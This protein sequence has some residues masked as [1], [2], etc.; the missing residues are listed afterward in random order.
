L[1]FRVDPAA[2][3]TFVVNSDSWQSRNH[4]SAEYKKAHSSTSVILNVVLTGPDG[5]P[6]VHMELLVVHRWF[7]KSLIKRYWKS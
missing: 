3:I 7:H 2:M 4:H 5:P 1:T 6:V